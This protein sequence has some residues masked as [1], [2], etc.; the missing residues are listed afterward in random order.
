MRTSSAAARRAS[1]RRAVRWAGPLTVG[2]VGLA[3]V[4]GLVTAPATAAVSQP[5][6]SRWPAMGGADLPRRLTHLGTSEQ[7]VVVTST[8]WRTSYATLRSFEKR[9][10]VWVE[11]L[12]PMP[13]RIGSNGFHTYAQRR[14]GDGT[15]PAG[16]YAFGRMFGSQ[17]NPG[18][19]YP[20]LRYDSLTY[21]LYNPSCPRSY[22]TL[23]RGT[24]SSCVSRQ[25]SERL[26]DYRL[27]Q[28]R[29]AAVIGYNLPTA[30][31]LADTTKGGGIF[32]HVNGKNATA[33]CVSLT[34][35]D[36]LSVL[37]WLDPTK[38]PL[39]VMGPDSVIA[40]M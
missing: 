18:V 39:I 4:A 33:G 12:R 11:M 2:S 1:I 34:E 30:T 15:T 6:P 23:W 24:S 25:W 37:R 14:Q 21:W 20:Y 19:R 32:L 9:N 29:Y 40:Q 35:P 7:V 26:W 22:N 38:H 16:T 28:Y 27:D 31:R 36:L 10:G 8:S 5:A 3:L 17:A 13:A